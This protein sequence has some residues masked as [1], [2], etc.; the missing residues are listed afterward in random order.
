VFESFSDAVQSATA[1]LLPLYRDVGFAYSV[2]AAMMLAAMLLGMAAVATH[3]ASCAGLEGRTRQ[4][5]RFISFGEP[6]TSGEFADDKEAVF[7]SRFAEIDAQMSKA[8][9]LTG[10]LAH[11]WRRYR[12]TLTFMARGPIRSTQRP[13]EF[14]YAVARPPSWLGFAATL[15]VAFGLLAT[16]LGLI[17][18]LTFAS[19]GMASND[20]AS[21]QAA[22]RD[23]LS[24]ASSKFVTSIAGVGLSILLRL[25]E[26]FLTYDLRRRLDRLSDA[27]ELGVRVDRDA[28]SASLA[29]RV[30]QLVE[31][32][33]VTDRANTK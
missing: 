33:D 13:N 6:T 11:A 7:A 9:P 25:L 16:F 29:Q 2:A 31:R 15:F 19:E 14:F 28:Q 27:I 32:L 21:M 12:K 30:G 17:A 20:M 8:G 26:R 3:I 24:A 10:G 23:L 22:I 5:S 1:S 4:I 18:A